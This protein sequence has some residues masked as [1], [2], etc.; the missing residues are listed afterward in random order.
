MNRSEATSFWPIIGVMPTFAQ[1]WLS[2][3]AW[4]ASANAALTCDF[5]AMVAWMTTPDGGAFSELTVPKSIVI[6]LTPPPTSPMW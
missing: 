2:R 5:R 3:K 1:D 4:S 6:P